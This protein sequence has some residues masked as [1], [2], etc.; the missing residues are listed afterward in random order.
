QNQIAPSARA[1]LSPTGRFSV[2]PLGRIPNSGFL[3][4]RKN[5]G[6]HELPAGTATRQRAAIILPFAPRK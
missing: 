5:E 3:E 6:I 4:S 2:T 1:S